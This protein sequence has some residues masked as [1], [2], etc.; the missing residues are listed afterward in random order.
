MYQARGLSLC[1]S[2][3]PLIYGAGETN[4]RH[5]AMRRMRSLITQSPAI[6]I[7]LLAIALSFGGGAYASTHGHASNYP[8]VRVSNSP[9]ATQAA[10]AAGVPWSSLTLINGWASENAVYGTGNPKVSEQNGIVYLSGSLAQSIP[11]SATFTILPPSFRPTH[12]LYITVYT[13]G[14]TTGTLYIDH[15]GVMEAYSATSCGSG[16]TAQCFTSLATVSF[17]INS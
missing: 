4:E 6:V 15:S 3:L 10:T 1:V 7:S 14:S 17:P 8:P 16:D 12:N 9:V 2:N 13:N 5:T 11:G